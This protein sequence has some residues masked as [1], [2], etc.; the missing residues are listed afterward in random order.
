MARSVPSR[1]QVSRFRVWGVGGRLH[2]YMY[3]DIHTYTHTYI[4]VYIST[5]IYAYKYS[6][7]HTYIY[8]YIYVNTYIC[9][10]IFIHTHI[11]IYI[12]LFS[13]GI[14]LRTV[15]DQME[16]HLSI[17][18]MYQPSHSRLVEILQDVDFIFYSE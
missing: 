8:T 3:I 6:Y 12:Y 15:L 1:P 13:Q 7:T 9:L 11:Y 10:Y 18:N 14:I 2:I 17:K 5:C 4:Y 16:I